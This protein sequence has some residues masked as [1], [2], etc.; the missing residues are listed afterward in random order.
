MPTLLSAISIVAAIAGGVAGISAAEAKI[1][2]AMVTSEVS[3]S[4]TSHSTT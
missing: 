4:E 3:G 1:K 2:V